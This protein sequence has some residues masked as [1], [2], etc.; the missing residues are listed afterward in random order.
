MRRSVA[1]EAGVA[2]DASSVVAPQTRDANS[3]RAAAARDNDDFM[4]RFAPR[5]GRGVRCYTG[6]HD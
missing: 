6:T 1:R 5:W 3:T 4:R 2:P